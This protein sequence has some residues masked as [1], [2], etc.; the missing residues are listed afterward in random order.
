M[1][2]AERIANATIKRLTR[3]ICR[4]DDRFLKHVPFKGPLILTANHINILDAPVVLTHLK[5]RIISGFAKAET[6]DNPLIAWLFNLWNAIPITRGEVDRKA[7]RHAL[8]ILKDGQI[9]A[10]APEGTRSGDGRLQRGYSGI[11]LLAMQSGA[12]IL[13]MAYYGGERFTDNIRRLRRTDFHIEVG[14]SYYLDAGGERPTKEVRQAMTDEIMYQIAALL[15][16]RYRGYYADLNLATE[17][18]LRFPPTSK[19][20]LRRAPI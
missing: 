7:L 3:M 1:R 19:S 9:L 16:Q 6:W 15:P 8:E 18:Y 10:V 13:P 11:T 14:D 4:V 5:P 2:M 12:P 20:N 17:K